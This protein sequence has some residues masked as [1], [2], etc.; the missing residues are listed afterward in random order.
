MEKTY[1]WRD[2]I[3]G[4]VSI[5][6]TMYQAKYAAHTGECTPEVERLTDTLSDQLKLIQQQ[7]KVIAL[8]EYGAWD[9]VELARGNLHS[10]SYQSI[11]PNDCRLVWIAANDIKESPLDYED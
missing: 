2:G 10:L 6:M 11:T 7:D 3:Y 9:G 4:K 1:T 8:Y 5:T